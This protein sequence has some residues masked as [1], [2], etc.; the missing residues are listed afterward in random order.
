MLQQLGD[1]FDIDVILQH[2]S[3]VMHNQS[4]HTRML[5]NLSQ[6]SGPS[7][8]ESLATVLELAAA[9]SPGV[10]ASVTSVRS[11]EGHTIFWS[12]FHLRMPKS[13]AGN[14]ISSNLVESGSNPLKTVE[15]R[16]FQNWFFQG[17]NA[18]TAEKHT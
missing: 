8:M 18:T 5:A 2:A 1:G 12:S 11:L 16:V 3:F 9:V 14:E 4:L 13:P 17:K 15:H 7:G 6:P 10:S